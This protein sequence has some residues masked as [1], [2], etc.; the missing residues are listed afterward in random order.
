[1]ASTEADKIFKAYYESHPI[2]SNSNSADEQ[3]IAN[4]LSD[5]GF[6]L[7]KEHK[8]ELAIKKYEEALSHYQ[9]GDIYYRY[10]NSLS[11]VN[12]LYEAIEAYKYALRL[13]YSPIKLVYYNTACAFSRIHKL[14]ITYNFL[15]L[16]IKNGYSNYKY[17]QTDPDLSFIR[18]QPGWK[19]WFSKYQ[20]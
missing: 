13:N 19:S 12:R 10:G 16:A 7:Y 15:E 2:D 20:K 14:K 18:S 8:D 9:T 4:T 5:E 17:L 6:A 1:M 11:N 3:K